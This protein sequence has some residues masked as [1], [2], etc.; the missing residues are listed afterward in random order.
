MGTNWGLSPKNWSEGDFN[1]DQSVDIGDFGLLGANFNAGV[2]SPL[3]PMGVGADGDDT[4]QQFIG[5]CALLGL[6]DSETQW[7]LSVL[8]TTGGQPQL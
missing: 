5:L 8:N 2:G 3:G 7:I 1:Y 4:V 6:S